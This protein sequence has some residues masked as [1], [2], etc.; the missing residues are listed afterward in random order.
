MGGGRESSGNIK[1]ILYFGGIQPVMESM[2]FPPGAIGYSKPD[3]NKQQ[4]NDCCYLFS[5]FIYT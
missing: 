4:P 2:L 1:L 3:G 5:S